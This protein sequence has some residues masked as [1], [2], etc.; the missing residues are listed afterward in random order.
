MKQYGN[1]RTVAYKGAQLTARTHARSR[2]SGRSY[3]PLEIQKVIVDRSIAAGVNPAQM[4]MMVHIETGGTFDP[5]SRNAKTGAAGLTQF[6]PANFKQYGLNHQS[7][8]D[9][10]TNIDAGIR[11]LKS[12][13]QHFMKQTGRRLK[14]EESYLLH[15]QGLAGG[16]ALLKYGNRLATEVLK[17]YYRNGVHIQAVVNNGGKTDWTAARFSQVF[18]SRGRRLLERYSG[19]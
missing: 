8:Y 16:T 3:N 14:E 17:P 15:Q 7:V 18:L 1:Q 6:M 10:I 9:P 4:L 5:W 13:A 2:Y 12:N 19:R 11:M